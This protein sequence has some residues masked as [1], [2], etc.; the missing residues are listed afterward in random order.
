MINRLPISIVIPNWNG[1]KF[2]ED[3]LESLRKIINKNFSVIIVD[4]GSNDNSVKLLKEKYLEVL[5][6]ENKQN[7]GFAAACNQGIR[8]AFKD[9]AEYILLLN[10]DTVIKPDF[11]AKM[12]KVI[13][14]EKGVG[15]VGCKIN[16]FSEPDRIWFAGGNFIRWRMS[17]KHRY[18]AEKD[19][20]SISGVQD[21]D[22]I[23][24]CCMLIRREVFEDIGYF[25]EPYF[26]SVED[27]DFCYQAKKAGW[28]IK[29]NLDAKIYHKVSMSR[30]GEFSFSN[31]YY[32]IRNR[33]FF[34]FK[35]TKNYFA[36]LVILFIIVPIRITQWPMQRRSQMLKGLLFGIKDFF[37]NNMDKIKK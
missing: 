15:I 8:Q 1:E 37:I 33:L 36:G 16:Y 35:R 2:L 28:K 31:G 7:L 19:K 3:C 22:F 27:L 5:L 20:D 21:S 26:L 25:F 30:E 34:A 9:G 4:N 10:N 13:K 29:V 32:G 17:G 14:D 23:T 18:W 11:L 24:G 6:I 12:V